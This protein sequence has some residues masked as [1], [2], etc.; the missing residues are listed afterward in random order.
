MFEM[1]FG[2]E[3]DTVIAI[4]GMTAREATNHVYEKYGIGRDTDDLIRTLG[5]KGF[6][7]FINQ[8]GIT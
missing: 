7:K 4:S 3:R 6:V 1:L 2:R 5:S 8:S